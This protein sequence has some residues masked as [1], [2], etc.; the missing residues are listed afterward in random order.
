MAA[1]RQGANSRLSAKNPALEKTEGGGFKAEAAIERGMALALPVVMGVVDLRWEWRAF[2]QPFDV[3]DRYLPPEPRS[4]HDVYLLSETS[5]ANV[6]I[7]ENAIDVKLLD[8]LEYGLEQWHPVFT[9]SFPLNQRQIRELCRYLRL[10]PP[11][12]YF[13]PEY[14][15]LSLVTDLISV[16]PEARVIGVYKTRRQ[17]QLDDCCIERTTLSVAG[18]VVH[19]AAI[20]STDPAAVLRLVARLQFNQFENVNYVT[21]LKRMIGIRNCP[22]TRASAEGAHHDTSSLPP[23]RTADGPVRLGST[24][25]DSG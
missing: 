25:S 13:A 2:S 23:S 19:T 6:K 4:S 1:S 18:H 5:D 7:R 10:A 20:E 9:A 17:A 12:A 16:S 15:P 11:I 22:N 21:F 3:L 14:G 8:R 24:S